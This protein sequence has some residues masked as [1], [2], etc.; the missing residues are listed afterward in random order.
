MHIFCRIKVRIYFMLATLQWCQQ[1]CGHENTC[2]I[3]GAYTCSLIAKSDSQFES[4][5]LSVKKSINN[6]HEN[7]NVMPRQLQG[8]HM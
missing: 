5:T 7:E 3:R 4:R 6:V 1:E 8:E 2:R